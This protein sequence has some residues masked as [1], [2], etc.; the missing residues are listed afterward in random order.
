MTPQTLTIIPRDVPT[1]REAL[2]GV[3]IAFGKVKDALVATLS[4]SRPST[5]HDEAEQVRELAA[6]YQITDPR[7]ADELF[8]AADRHERRTAK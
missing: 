2:R 5:P 3:R 8:A 6:S 7:F 4:L 1:V